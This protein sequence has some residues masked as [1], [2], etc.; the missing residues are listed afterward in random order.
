MLCVYTGPVSRAKFTAQSE[1]VRRLGTYPPGRR[2]QLGGSSGA[3]HVSIFKMCVCVWQ[4]GINV[5]VATV[6]GLDA[7]AS[8]PHTAS[9]QTNTHTHTHTGHSVILLPF[10]PI[11]H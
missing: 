11:S 3:I 9:V 2:L 1:E 10:F 6:C 7:V 8:V 4:E 5:C